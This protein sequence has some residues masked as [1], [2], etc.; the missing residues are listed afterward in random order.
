MKTTTPVRP[1]TPPPPQRHPET[2]LSGALQPTPQHF[3]GQRRFVSSKNSLFGQRGDRRRWGGWCCAGDPHPHPLAA[4]HHAALGAAPDPPLPSSY[5]PA[6]TGGALGGLWGGS[7]SQCHHQNWGSAGKVPWG[8]LETGNGEMSGEMGIR[9]LLFCPS[10]NFFFFHLLRLF[11]TF[12][13]FT[14]FIFF[15]F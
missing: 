11:F 3:R 1:P 6:Q 5:G 4:L 8:H 15:F 14:L 7:Q 9:I 10:Y 13:S 12:S 2:T